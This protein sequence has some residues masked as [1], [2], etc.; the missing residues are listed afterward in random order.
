MSYHVMSC[1]I[2]SC[3]EVAVA[4]D[5]LDGA[6]YKQSIIKAAAVELQDLRLDGAV[7]SRERSNGMI[8][9]MRALCKYQTL[10]MET[11]AI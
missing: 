8:S 1:H 10:N 3:H 5:V 2:M 4:L 7:L 9:L 11:N 6:K